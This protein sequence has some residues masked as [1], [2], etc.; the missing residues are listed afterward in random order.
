MHSSSSIALGLL[1]PLLGIVY[2][3]AFFSLF[4]Q[5]RGLY[6]S[7]GIR[8]IA[9]H[10][11]RVFRQVGRDAWRI[12]PSIF[13]LN[14]SDPFLLGCVAAGVALGLVLAA[15]F[16]PLPLLVALWLLYLSFTT[17]GH[18][19]LSYQWDALLLETGFWTIFLPLAGPSSL[20]E[21]AYRLFIFRFMFS[22]GVVKLTSGDPV[23][24]SLRAL[25]VHYQTQPLPNRLAWHA[26]QLPEWVQRLSTFGTFVFELAVPF[27]VLGPAPLRIAGFMLLVAFQG[28]LMLTGSYGFFNL[29][30]IVLCVPLLEDRYLSPLFAAGASNAASPV[31]AFLGN[32]A[33]LLFVLFNLLQLLRLFFRPAWLDRLFSWLRP[34]W[35]SNPYGLFAVMTTERNELVIE[36]SEDGENWHPY[37]FRWKPGDPGT[38]P[39]QAA[40]HQPRLDWQMWFAALNP[41]VIEPWLQEF[42]RRLLEGSPPVLR[43][44]RHAPFSDRRPTSV[45]LAVYRY[46]YTDREERR[47]TGDWWHR[48]LLGRSQP[49][50]LKDLA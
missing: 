9:E 37:E 26:H 39:R 50:S 19:F 5:V 43:L 14:A 1:P 47:S 13:W 30:T 28:L 23:W 7:S 42:L 46:R 15:G 12:Y 21:W 18:E 6:G 45:R 40:P 34:W 41:A 8:P 3:V 2:A 16:W 33:L 27:L 11:A 32:A 36:G 22:A 48:T 20:A 29:L 49:L 44:L 10:T 31:A 38:A 17:L 24:R 25:C 35:V 4:V